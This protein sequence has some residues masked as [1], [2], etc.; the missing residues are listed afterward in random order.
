MESWKRP[1]P[2][3][4]QLHRWD[5]TWDEALH[6]YLGVA[7]L[8]SDVEG[9]QPGLLHKAAGQ[10]AANLGQYSFRTLNRAATQYDSPTHFDP[11]AMQLDFENIE[12]ALTGVTQLNPR[13]SNP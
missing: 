7:A 10:L 2:E 1:V 12:Q 9:E 4:P 11:A 8:A 5:A 3:N 13:P 6:L